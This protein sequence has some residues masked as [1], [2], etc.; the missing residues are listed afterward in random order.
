MNIQTRKLSIINYI[1]NLEDDKEIRRIEA[2]ILKKMRKKDYR[3][4]SQEE[5]LAR[6]KESMEDYKKGNCFT[7]DEIEDEYENWLLNEE[8]ILITDVFD[9]RQNP[10][11]MNKPER[12]N[13]E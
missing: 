3:P 13:S 11:Q 5:L 10:K 12:K 2:D 1:I 7:Q 8:K 4:F 6:V 9:T